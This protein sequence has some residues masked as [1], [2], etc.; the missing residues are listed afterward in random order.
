MKITTAQLRQIIKEEIEK[1]IG[2]VDEG[3][4]DKL[5]NFKGP[6]IAAGIGAAA[7]AGFKA[8]PQDT[9]KAIGAQITAIEFP[10]LVRAEINKKIMKLNDDN[11]SVEERKQLEDEIEKLQ[12]DLVVAGFVRSGKR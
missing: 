1:E 4:M 10:E 6:L 8:L 5:K 7:G 11:L 12:H 2:S 3:L 9:K